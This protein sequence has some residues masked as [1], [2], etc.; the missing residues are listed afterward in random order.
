MKIVFNLLVL[1]VLIA[2]QAC[3]DDCGECFTPPSP[4]MF[5]LVDKTSAEN[6]F[7]NGTFGSHQIEV[8]NSIDKSIVDFTFIDDNNIIRLNSIGW[9]TETVNILV[10]ISNENIF[11]LF[12]DLESVNENCCSF[13]RYN[14]IR[15]ENAEFELDTN[16]GVYKILL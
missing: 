11:S 7:A 3:K 5:E 10:N 13:T 9:Q 2:V 8:V 1:S 6:L 15:I 12:V 4:F 16:T 14:E